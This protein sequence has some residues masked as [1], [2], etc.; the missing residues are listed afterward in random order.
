MSIPYHK[1]YKSIETLQ[2]EKPMDIGAE[3][4]EKRQALGITQEE[5]AEKIK[6]S[7]KTISN[8][9]TGKTT[10]DS[11]NF[12]LLNDLLRLSV[13][14]PSPKGILTIHLDEIPIKLFCII[15][16]LFLI[17]SSWYRMKEITH[18]RIDSAHQ[19]ES[20]YFSETTLFIT[21]DLPFYQTY[22]AQMTGTIG[23]TAQ[24]SIY[25]DFSLFRHE[26]TVTISLDRGFYDNVDIIEIVDENFSPIYTINRLESGWVETHNGGEE[27]NH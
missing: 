8:W 14:N 1:I 4:K 9:E 12:L 5:L 15:I 23:N 7:S 2:M 20:V 6:V 27:T 26:D 17:G 24:M 16:T 10:P 3:I 11:Y 18:G 19:I 21:L 22:S 25:T 13:K